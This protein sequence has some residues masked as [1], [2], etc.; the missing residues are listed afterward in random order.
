MHRKSS[1]K[2]RPLERAF[3][4]VSSYKDYKEKSEAKIKQGLIARKDWKKQA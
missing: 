4:T 1:G 2:K 3:F